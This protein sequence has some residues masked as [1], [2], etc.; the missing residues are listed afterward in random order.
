LFLEIQ[1][2][3][4]LKRN[5]TRILLLEFFYKKKLK[6]KEMKRTKPL[7]LE[8]KKYKKNVFVFISLIFII[9]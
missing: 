4:Q 9:F 1:K 8:F 7:I 3:N 5:K 6:K 2:K